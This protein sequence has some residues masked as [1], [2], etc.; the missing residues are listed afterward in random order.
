MQ[1]WWYETEVD[2]FDHRIKCTTVRYDT[3]PPL[4]FAPVSQLTS[5][6]PLTMAAGGFSPYHRL[7]PDDAPAECTGITPTPWAMMPTLGMVSYH[8]GH[9]L[10]SP[11]HNDTFVGWSFL[12]RKFYS[13]P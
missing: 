5:R 7:W 3:L 12:V 1:V 2:D 10:L 4:L 11:P 8:Q 6:F 9:E 13:I